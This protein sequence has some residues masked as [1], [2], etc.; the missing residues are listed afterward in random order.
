MSPS[1]DFA[2]RLTETL[3]PGDDGLFNPWRDACRFQT[4]END[5]ESRL[6]RLALHLSIDPDFILVGEAPGYAGC[7]YSGVAFTSER[8]LLEGAIPRVPSPTARL[9]ERDKPFSEPSATIVWKTL[10]R[11]GIQD[12]TV[13]W[14]ALQMHP[15]HPGHPWSN[16]TPRDDE[17]ALGMPALRMLVAAFPGAA[18]VAIGKK[19][20]GLLDA[21]GIRI[22]A[23]VRHP[24]NGGASAFADG[25]SRAVAAAC[26]HNGRGVLEA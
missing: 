26:L 17:L 14:N 19:S 15:H 23:A 18:V 24:A 16:R 2:H 8:L 6:R 1:L 20:Q 12:R 7:R 21:C 11:I 3:P 5:A 9:S 10:Y 22:T 25:L 4:Q 13:L